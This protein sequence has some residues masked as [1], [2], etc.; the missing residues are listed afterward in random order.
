[1]I[2]KLRAKQRYFTTE[3][4][5]NYYSNGSDVAYVSFDKEYSL[6]LN[7]KSIAKTK[8]TKSSSGINYVITDCEN[9]IIGYIEMQEIKGLTKTTMVYSLFDKTHLVIANSDTMS[10]I[11]KEFFIKGKN[12]EL[13]AKRDIVNIISENWT[14]NQIGDLD[15]RLVLLMPA[16][17]IITETKRRQNLRK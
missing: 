2:P 13:S 1:M 15:Q 12:V 16:I 7:G 9:V 11:S 10:L 3:T 5:L 14:I 17:K 4:R 6:L 8:T